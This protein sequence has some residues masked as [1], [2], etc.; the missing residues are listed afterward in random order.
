MIQFF[1]FSVVRVVYKYKTKGDKHG[2]YLKESLFKFEFQGFLEH[3]M[4]IQS[5][6]N[7]LVIESNK[8]PKWWYHRRVKIIGISSTVLIILA[9]S[10]TVILEFSIRSS[11]RSYSTTTTT[12]QAPG[13]LRVT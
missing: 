6:S 7:Q 3:Y 8:R 11:K 2:T 5:E 12:T 10:L 4:D 13:K 9:V 1:F